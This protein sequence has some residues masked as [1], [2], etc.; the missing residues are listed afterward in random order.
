MIW[1]NCWNA[2]KKLAAQWTFQQFPTVI[3]AVAK[4]QGVALADRKNFDDNIKK[5][6]DISEQLMLL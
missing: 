4:Y 6:K 5:W 1:E 2:I 3:K